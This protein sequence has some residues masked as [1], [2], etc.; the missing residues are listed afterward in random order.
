MTNSSLIEDVERYYTAKVKTYGAT[1]AGVDWNSARSQQVR[2]EQ[3]LA[4]IGDTDSPFSLNDFGCGYGSLLDVLAA[5]W[6]RFD[7]RGFDISEA[8]IAEAQKRHAGDHRASF[9]SDGG[10]LRPADYTVASGVFNVRLEQ[11][12]QVWRE[13]VL[14]TID[15][16]ASVSY[17][18]MAF[19][20]LTS[21][22]DPD[23]MRRD[24]YYA[25]PAELLDYCLRNHSRDIVL[26][27]DY[28][29]YEFTVIVQLDRRQPSCRSS[30]GSSHSE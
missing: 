5:R 4:V 27:H 16:L 25:D 10:E 18:G 13:Y 12:E 14:A 11:P 22:S 1:P 24:L 8:M 7:Y 29:L 3:L 21:Q 23:R 15:K 30:R 28:E 20:A 17:R 9:V 6:D 19:N 2:F 26:R